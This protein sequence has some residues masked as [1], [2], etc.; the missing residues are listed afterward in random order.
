MQDNPDATHPPNYTKAEWDQKQANRQRLASGQ[1]ARGHPN[2]PSNIS[3]LNRGSL[4]EFKPTPPPKPPKK[5]EDFRSIYDRT[6]P[7]S[8]KEEPK[9]D[10]RGRFVSGGNRRFKQEQLRN[11]PGRVGADALER[12]LILQQ[13]AEA[14][15]RAREN[16]YSLPRRN[17][18]L[19]PQHR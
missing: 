4:Y 13:E 8:P 18:F 5:E 17:Q 10:A 6:P 11:R 3:I 12:E 9:R 2:Q 7:P 19:R 16:R 1:P 14:R 15:Q